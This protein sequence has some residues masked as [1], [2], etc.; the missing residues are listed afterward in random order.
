MASD[1]SRTFQR[2]EIEVATKLVREFKRTSRSLVH[3]EAEDLLQECLMRWFEVRQRLTP[4]DD[5]PPLAYM[6][7][8]LRN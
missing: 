1:G 3:E 8:V 4:N 5:G 7:R 6:A 2:W